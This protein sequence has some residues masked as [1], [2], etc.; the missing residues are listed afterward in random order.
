MKKFLIALAIVAVL[1]VV[2]F[3]A[4]PQGAKDY[5]NYYKI[6]RTDPTTYNEIQSCREAIV[7]T[8]VDSSNPKTYADIFDKC[9][10]YEYWTYEEVVNTDGSVSKTITGNGSRVTLAYGESGDRGV[11]QSAK[12]KFVFLLDGRGGYT[13]N[14]YTGDTLLSESDRNLMLQ[15]MC[16][17][18]GQ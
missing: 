5:L 7:L 11:L 4:L 16:Q 13:L 14:V 1:A 8:D 3:F 9:A 18:A 15:K 2:I 10:E 17:L 12:I 6:Q